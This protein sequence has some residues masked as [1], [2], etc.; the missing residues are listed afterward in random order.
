MSKLNLLGNNIDDLSRLMVSLGERPF[1]GKQLFKWLYKFQQYDFSLMTDLRKEIRGRLTDGYTFRGLKPVHVSRSV[2]GT[3]KFLFRLDDGYPVEAVVIPEED[4]RTVCLS[5][6]AGCA[7]RCR[8]CATGTMGL[9]RDLTIGE[10]VGQLVFIRE[11]F[12]LQAFRNIVLMGMGEPLNNYDNVIES[13]RIM[14]NEYGMD[15]S[16]RRITVSTCGITPGIIHLAD[17][18]LKPFL[19]ISLHVAIQE[20]RERIMPIARKFPL[21][22]L[23]EAARYYAKKTKTRV[24]IEYIIFKGFNDTEED[25]RALSRLLRGLPC[26]I[27]IL[28]YNPVVGLD[29]ER[30]SDE[31][32]D[33]FGQLLYPHLPAVTV[34][35][36]R[37]LDIE[38]ACGQLAAQNVSGGSQDE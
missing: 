33:R 37:G 36:S 15:I 1:K 22:E 12:G 18:N 24:T 32:V 26:K 8:F 6:Q 10:I 13:I 4:R 38:A 16:P 27:N 23:I 9:L 2:D 11:R 7:L 28:A 34:R 14:S 3:E 30:P 17:S 20:K 5:S 35:R 25:V 21:D 31:E 29:F 19:A